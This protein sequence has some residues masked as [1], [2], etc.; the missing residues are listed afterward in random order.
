MTIH[1]W[2]FFSR[3]WNY[4]QVGFQLHQGL[5]GVPHLHDFHYCGSHY[6]SFWVMYTQV[7]DFRISRGPPTVLLTRILH[8]A[9][10]SSPKIHVRRGILYFISSSWLINLSTS[11]SLGRWLY[12]IHHLALLKDIVLISNPVTRKKNHIPCVLLLLMSNFFWLWNRYTVTA[13]YFTRRFFFQ[14]C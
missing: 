1:A 13:L 3:F 12:L 11:S 14:M 6:R 5:Q 10:F 9:V 8:N 7:G 2:L 4:Y